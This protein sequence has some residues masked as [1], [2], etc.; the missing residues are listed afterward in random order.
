LF[1]T[2]ARQRTRT[3]QWRSGGGVFFG[4]RPGC[5]TSWLQR[6]RHSD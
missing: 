6:F 3:Q 2:V 4:V 1:T 5:H